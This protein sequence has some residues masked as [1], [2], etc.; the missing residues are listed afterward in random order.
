MTIA[1]NSV[2]IGDYM[3][4]DI[5]GDGVINE[6]DRTYIGNPEPDF[7]F[8]FGNTFSYKGFDLSVYLSDR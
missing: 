3:F 4:E 8:G 6:E 7:T 2:W 5:N 1:K